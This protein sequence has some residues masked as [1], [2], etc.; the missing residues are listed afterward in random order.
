MRYLLVLTLLISSSLFGYELVII[1][2]ISD[3][4]RT[5]ITRGGKKD[6]I[7]VG[8]KSTF[9][10][11]N[12]SIIAKAIQVSRGFTQWKVQNSKIPTPFERED[13]VT[14]YDAQEYLWALSPEEI[15]RKY[16]KEEIWKPRFSLGAHVALFTGINSSTSVADD[17]SE[18]RGGLVF[19]GMAEQEFTRNLALAGGLR[20]SREIINVAAASLTNSQ[21]VGI[22]EVRYYFDKMETF[23][24]A[25]LALALGVGWGQSQTTTSGQT[26]SGYVTLLPITKA[27]MT[28]PVNRLTDLVL[29]TA[30]ES[31]QIDEEFADGATQSTTS[32]NFKYG[33]AFKRYFE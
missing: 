9:T 25:R 20:F 6:G 29:E 12:V 8:K 24:D 13:V 7:F 14:M 16:I 21:F 23:Y 30:F 10:K 32:D 18:D 3:S 2:T 33:I 27:F 15:K 1:Q 28:I 17:V 26:S 11:K 5:F 19:E 22:G 31:S 4:G